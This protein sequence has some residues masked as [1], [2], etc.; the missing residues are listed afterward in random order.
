MVDSEMFVT[1]TSHRAEHAINDNIAIFAGI[2]FIGIC[3]M[4]DHRHA[5]LPERQP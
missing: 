1:Q 3:L 4:V 2:S 5:V